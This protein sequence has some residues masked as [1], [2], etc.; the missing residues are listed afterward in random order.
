MPMLFS[1]NKAPSAPASLTLDLAASRWNW[2]PQKIFLRIF[3]QSCTCLFSLRSALI[4]GR[5]GNNRPVRAV[6]ASDALSFPEP[7]LGFLGL[8][9]LA[10]K[11]Q[12]LISLILILLLQFRRISPLGKDSRCSTQRPVALI[13]PMPCKI[14]RKT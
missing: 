13:G 8:L 12:D 5:S 9:R 2:I 11:N 3:L 14:P 1:V 7:L 10:P 6:S 4:L